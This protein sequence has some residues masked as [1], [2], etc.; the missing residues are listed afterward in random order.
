ME[1]QT[2]HLCV[3]CKN[4]WGEDAPT[5]NYYTISPMTGERIYLCGEHAFEVVESGKEIECVRDS[6]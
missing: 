2:R 1:N 5:G 3:P 6:E 4:T